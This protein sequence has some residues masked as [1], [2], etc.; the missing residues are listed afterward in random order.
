MSRAKGYPDNYDMLLSKIPPNDLP[1]QSQHGGSGPLARDPSIPHSLSVPGERLN[2]VN[3]T[4][5]SGMLR[6]RK[7]K[8]KVFHDQSALSRH[9]HVPIEQKLMQKLRRH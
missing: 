4:T 1:P 5:S 9:R 3:T 6:T 2:T 7:N 8:P